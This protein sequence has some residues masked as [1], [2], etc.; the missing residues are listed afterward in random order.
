[1]LPVLIMNTCR[2]ESASKMYWVLTG[3]CTYGLCLCGRDGTEGVR[4]HRKHSIQLE[5]CFGI[6]FLILPGSGVSPWPC[7]SL[8]N[9]PLVHN[10]K[11]IDTEQSARVG[12]KDRTVR[13][14]Q[15]SFA[16]HHSVPRRN[17]PCRSCHPSATKAGPGSDMEIV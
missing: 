16:F 10:A 5:D 11:T 7:C 15:G 6:C 2:Y 1:L 12:G 14:D 8:V 3:N 4:D 17:V 9:L 13:P